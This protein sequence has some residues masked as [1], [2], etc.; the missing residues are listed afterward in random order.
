MTSLLLHK[1]NCKPYAVEAMEERRT[2]SGVER[3]VKEISAFSSYSM[4]PSDRRMHGYLAD[5]LLPGS[6]NQIQEVFVGNTPG[7]FLQRPY[8]LGS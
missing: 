3:K 2:K 5:T 6:H 1:S 7:A 8:T 4:L